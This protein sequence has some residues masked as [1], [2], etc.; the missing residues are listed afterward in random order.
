MVLMFLPPARLGDV[1]IRTSAVVLSLG[2]HDPLASV[3]RLVLHPTSGD[4]D[5]LLLTLDLG[6]DT[7]LAVAARV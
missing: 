7:S 6:K 4:I 3:T 1:T 5:T 2:S